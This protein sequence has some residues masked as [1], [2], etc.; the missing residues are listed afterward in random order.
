MY[1]I[2]LQTY[3]GFNVSSR[4]YVKGIIFKD[5]YCKRNSKHETMLGGGGPWYIVPC[6]FRPIIAE[7][8]TTNE[9]TNEI[10]SMD[11]LK[12][13]LI[14]DYFLDFQK[15]EGWHDLQIGPWGYE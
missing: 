7:K 15:W 3:N 12:A 4:I 6:R 8:V 10:I 11:Q 14:V 13:K 9:I 1:T 2:L 5:S